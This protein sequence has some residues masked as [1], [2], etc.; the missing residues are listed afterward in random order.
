MS[1]PLRPPGET[2]AAEGSTAEAHQERPDGGIWE[3]PRI[4]V[5]LIAI[6]CLLFAAFFLVRM[7]TL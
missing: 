3:H 4:W 5:A 7:V 2:P 6:G 1:E